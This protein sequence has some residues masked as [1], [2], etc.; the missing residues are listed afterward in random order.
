[1]GGFG[2]VKKSGLLRNQHAVKVPRGDADDVADINAR[3]VA[4]DA[5]WASFFSTRLPRES[6][7]SPRKLRSAT[8]S[9]TSISS[10]TFTGLASLGGASAAVSISACELMT[11]RGARNQRTDEGQ[12][13]PRKCSQSRVPW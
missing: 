4:G 5:V 3:T 9:F 13:H 7:F 12:S 6:L 8:Y 1:M 11:R 2:G 10:E